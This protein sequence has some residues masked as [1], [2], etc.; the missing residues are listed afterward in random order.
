MSQPERAYS[1][2]SADRPELGLGGGG[3]LDAL[4]E[5]GTTRR[6]RA[7]QVLLR[8][9]TEG[10][11]LFLILRGHLKVATANEDGRELVLRIMGPG[12]LV[13][14]IA[15][16]DG[17]RRS[18]TIIALEPVELLAMRRSA[19]LDLLR[20][21]PEVALKLLELVASR[22]RS[23]SELFEDTTSRRLPLRL[24][25][26]LLSLARSF[27]NRG[28]A[29]LH[30]ELGLSQQDLGEMVATSRESVNKQIR[31]WTDAAV[32]T[33]NRR[34]ITIHDELTLARLAR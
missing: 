10:S 34:R 4:R 33:M 24:A 16:L 1:V 29:G 12:E 20:R 6:L 21:R 28:P 5:I 27:G 8:K 23:L 13:G 2:R 31:A 17:G 9:G 25:R 7:R 30:I 14:E 15:L 19:L 3:P 18:A 32:L 22:L 11:E 26:R